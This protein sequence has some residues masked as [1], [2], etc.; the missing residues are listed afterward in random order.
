MH[1]LLGRQ[2]ITVHLRRRGLRDV[3][4]LTVQTTEITTRTGQ[5]EA[6]GA[7][8]EMIQRLLFHRVD[9][10]RTGLAIHL[11]HEHPLAIAT[12]A[13]DARPALADTAMMRAQLTL[14]CTPFQFAI[15]PTLVIIHYQL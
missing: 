5:G 3:V 7:R 6:C 12:T 15:I 9:G 13:T 4:V 1:Q 14:D 2:M 10:Q 8:V 11:A